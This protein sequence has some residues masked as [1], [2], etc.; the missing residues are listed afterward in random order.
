MLK[1]NTSTELW[2]KL[3]TLSAIRSVLQYNAN[4]YFQ[5]NSIVC[6][7]LDVIY[8]TKAHKNKNCHDRIKKKWKIDSLHVYSTELYTY[9]HIIQCLLYV[10]F[11][12]LYLAICTIL[13]I[14]L[15]FVYNFVGD[16]LVSMNFMIICSV[17]N[18][19]DDSLLYVRICWW[20]FALCTISSMIFCSMYGLVHNTFPCVQF[21]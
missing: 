14:I 7:Y 18:F 11:R 21:L 8:E 20:H 1:Q 2:T 12:W 17:Y 16:S 15:W 10:Q 9:T 5:I 13:L 3:R 6:A 4:M 19:V